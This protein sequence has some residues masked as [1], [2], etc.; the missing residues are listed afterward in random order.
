MNTM[1][2]I[3]HINKVKI[4]LINLDKQKQ[5]KIKVLDCKINLMV[6]ILNCQNKLKKQDMQ[7]GKDGIIVAKKIA[8]I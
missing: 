1:E 6:L 7:L 3:Q 8:M 2:K 5:I 4:N